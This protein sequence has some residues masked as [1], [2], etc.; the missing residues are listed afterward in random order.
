MIYFHFPVLTPVAKTAAEFAE[1][2]CEQGQ[3]HF[4]DYVGAV[5]RGQHGLSNQ[6]LSDLAATLDIDDDAMDQC[7]AAGRHTAT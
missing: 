7:V 6:S 4:W 1:C 3:E 2:A 5:Y